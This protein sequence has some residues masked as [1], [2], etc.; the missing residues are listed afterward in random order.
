MPNPED[1]PVNDQLLLMVISK[2]ID[3][4]DHKFK[5]L[6]MYDLIR[7]EEIL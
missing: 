6:L 4:I 3:I 2:I 7:I 1:L 5:T